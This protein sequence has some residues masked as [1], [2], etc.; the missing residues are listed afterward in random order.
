MARLLR[1]AI[2]GGGG[3]RGDTDDDASRVAERGN[4]L[5][6]GQPDPAQP[7][8][9]VHAPLREAV[10]RHRRRYALLVGRAED[11]LGGVEDLRCPLPGPLEG[12][13]LDLVRDLDHP[14]ALTT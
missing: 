3:M 5:A 7:S 8:D 1:K 6:V 4:D 9:L 2:S 10:G 11:E 12:E 14:P 13:P